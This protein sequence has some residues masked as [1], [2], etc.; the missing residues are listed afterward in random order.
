M[1]ERSKGP[2]L[3]AD[4]TTI[5][6]GGPA[7]RLVE[8]GTATHLSG[9]VAAADTEGTPVLILAGGSNVVVSDDGFDGL[10]V[11]PTGTDGTRAELP[12]G[13][14]LLDY[15]AGRN[16]DALVE[17]TTA[18]GL[19]GIEALSGIPG[20]LGA[21]P[22]QNIGAYGQE[23]SETLRGVKVYDRKLR[24][25]RQFSN[26]DCR[27]SYR[28]S[29]FKQTDR[30]V[31]LSVQLQLEASPLSRPVAYR[32]LARK[33]GVETGD[34][35]PLSDLR[36]AVLELRRGKGMV[37]DPAD[38]DTRSA[39]SFFLNPVVPEAAAAQLPEAAPRWPAGPGL[40][41]LSAAWLIEQA[42]FSR[43]YSGGRNTAALSGR[44]TLAITNRGGAT[45]ADIVS[46]AAELRD[47]VL[48]AF[49]IELV[50]EPRLVGI[51]LLRKDVPA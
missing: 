36:A 43:G 19:S 4:H 21:A 30:Y 48:A 45:A 10:V 13:S 22:L 18:G 47:G 11:K 39:G 51:D 33:L 37:L 50:P 46:L 23:L 40:V 2:A 5:G 6:V 41:K 38:P 8:A 27:F 7:A 44:H 32:E 15:E 28:N 31:I 16:W 42:G 20:S 1:S 35:V 12:D 29:I 49:G 34:R 25:T 17:E 9:L 24:R 3:L 14:V 26:E